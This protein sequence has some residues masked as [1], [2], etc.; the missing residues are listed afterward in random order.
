ME[1]TC[2]SSLS[3]DTWNNFITFSLSLI[4]KYLKIKSKEMNRNFIRFTALFHKLLK[5]NTWMNHWTMF[6]STLAFGDIMQSIDLSRLQKIFRDFKYL[7]WITGN[8]CTHSTAS[9]SK[10]NNRRMLRQ[11]YMDSGI[12]WSIPW[13]RSLAWIFRSIPRSMLFGNS[14]NSDEIFVII[15]ISFF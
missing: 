4:I 1:S 13:N 2:P 9:I 12:P 8:C 3:I 15:N 11:R 7:T 10:T 6:E 14:W 5:T